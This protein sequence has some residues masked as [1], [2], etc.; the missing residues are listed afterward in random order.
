M[1]LFT[2]VRSVKRGR[3]ISDGGRPQTRTDFL[4]E[5][6]HTRLPSPRTSLDYLKNLLYSHLH[7]SAGP[8]EQDF[9][10]ELSQ[11]RVRPCD[12]AC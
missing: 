6:Y 3:K 4:D 1:Q 5:Y 2:N 9:L 11:D 7:P 10:P 8:R 12:D